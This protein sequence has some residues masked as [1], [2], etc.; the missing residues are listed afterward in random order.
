MF[1][2]ICFFKILK[3]C[4]RDKI[5]NNGVLKYADATL[6]S[7]TVANKLLESRSAKVA[8]PGYPVEERDKGTPMKTWRATVK[9]YAKEE[10]NLVWGT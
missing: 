5:R 10:G 6:L 9:K 3:I 8:W 2:L 4:F 7:D 1:Y